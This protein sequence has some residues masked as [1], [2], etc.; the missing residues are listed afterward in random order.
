MSSRVCI[1]LATVVFALIVSAN[2]PT[3]R[4]PQ[5]PLTSD[6]TNRRHSEHTLH[7]GPHRRYCEVRLRHSTRLL[8]LR[9]L[10]AIQRRRHLRCHQSPA[11][12]RSK[13]WA[14][15]AVPRATPT[16]LRTTISIS[17]SPIPTV[18]PSASGLPNLANSISASTS[19]SRVPKA[20]RSLPTVATGLPLTDIY[21]LLYIQ[22]YACTRLS[23]SG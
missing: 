10:H 7:C 12:R 18:S 11:R 21:V 17:I 8:H 22:I 9:E 14:R 16:P 23:S 19:A 6:Q 2:A 15:A 5:K 20:T 13:P 4:A 3:V 1:P